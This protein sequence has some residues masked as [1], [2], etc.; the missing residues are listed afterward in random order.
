MVEA[1]EVAEVASSRRWKETSK[2]LQNTGLGKT[3]E[4]SEGTGFTSSA[5]ILSNKIFNINISKNG[6]SVW[7][8]KSW[9]RKTK[10]SRVFAVSLLFVKCVW[11]C[12]QNYKLCK[13]DRNR[14]AID[15]FFAELE[16][17]RFHAGTEL[18]GPLSVLQ[19]VLACVSERFLR[20]YSW[21]TAGSTLLNQ[22]KEKWSKPNQL[23]TCVR[24][25]ASIFTVFLAITLPV[26]RNAP[27]LRVT[28]VLSRRAR[29][30]ASTF[31]CISFKHRNISLM[32]Q[33]TATSSYKIT[34]SFTWWRF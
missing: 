1:L 3:L 32:Q 17:N 27:F 22:G 13:L 15:C 9:Q 34:L 29:W 5:I 16:I 14:L 11:K 21:F 12:M 33:K 8:E 25:I 7:L 28:A 23:T 19:S 30:D 31:A 24:F 10:Q 20:V 4:H 26:N 6:G 2:A 18:D